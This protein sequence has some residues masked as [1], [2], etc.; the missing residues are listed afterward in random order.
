MSGS[1]DIAGRTAEDSAGP[2][3]DTARI[4]RLAHVSGRVQ[5][6][7]FRYATRD[8]ADRLG[9]TGYARNLVDGRVEVLVDGA[10]DSVR[11]MLDWLRTGPPT[12]SVI[13]VEVSDAESGRFPD[14][15]IR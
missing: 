2:A 12:A 13:D 15:A 3:A 5:G 14:F 4:A 11:E 6:V 8:A 1:E 10:P 9:V 7:G